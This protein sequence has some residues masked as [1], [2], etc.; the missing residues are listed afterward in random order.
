MAHEVTELD[1]HMCTIEGNGEIRTS[2][3]GQK[4]VSYSY[5]YNYSNTLAKHIYAI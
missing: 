3:S 5:T 2:W 1:K 4:G